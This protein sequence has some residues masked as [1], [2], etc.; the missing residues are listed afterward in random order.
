MSSKTAKFVIFL[1]LFEMQAA[2]KFML[3]PDPE[4]LHTQFHSN[5]STRALCVTYILTLGFQ[6]LTYAT[7]DRQFWPWVFLMLTH[8]VEA[9]MWWTLG[10]EAGYMDGY[11]SVPDF[12][13]AAVTR[14]HPKAFSM[15]L[16]F[17]PV[18]IAILLISG[19]ESGKDSSNDKKKK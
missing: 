6:R 15:I 4:E 19:P 8:I 16:V 14:K 5:P 11:D 3:Y 2:V 13:Q 7:G 12:V 17:V 10:I 18:I 9:W 1:G